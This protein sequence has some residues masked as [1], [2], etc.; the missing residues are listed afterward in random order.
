MERT[1]RADLA[2]QITIAVLSLI[3]IGMISSTG[4]LHRWGFV[5]GLV[6]QPFWIL[7]TWRARQHGMLFLSVFYLFVWVHGIANRFTF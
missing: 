4:P 5:V 3:A 6:S 1:H 2:L 7:A